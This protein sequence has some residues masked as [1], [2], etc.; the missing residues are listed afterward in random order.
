MKMYKISIL[1]IIFFGESVSLV[2]V[3]LL[4]LRGVFAVG[5]M[6]SAREVPRKSLQQ[7]FQWKSLKTFKSIKIS[8]FSCS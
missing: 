6:I 8:R 4:F 7:P 1:E 3:Q 5:V 2:L